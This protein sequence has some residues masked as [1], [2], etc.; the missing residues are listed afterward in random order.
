MSKP[1]KIYK[2]ARQESLNDTDIITVEFRGQEKEIR[3]VEEYGLAAE[4]ARRNGITRTYRG[5]GRATNAARRRW[6]TGEH[7]HAEVFAAVA[8]VASD[9]VEHI[10]N[11]PRY[12]DE[13]RSQPGVMA[14]ANQ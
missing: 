12:G 3:Y 2:E 13:C 7:R 9:D 5:N 11:A 4:D 8:S 6:E 1:L 10:E 14:V